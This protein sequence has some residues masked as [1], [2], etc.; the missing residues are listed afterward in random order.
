MIQFH[1]LNG[2]T[3]AINPD[4]IERVEE[5]P[6]TVVTLL[7]DKKFLVSESLEEVLALITDYR[8]YVIARSTDLSIVNEER[9]TLHVVPNEVVIASGRVCSHDEVSP[10]DAEGEDD[11][12]VIKYLGDM[13]IS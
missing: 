8:A 12:D 2:K 6:D 9:P 7:D 3:I 4:L 11:A 5:T 10:E 1:R 13:E